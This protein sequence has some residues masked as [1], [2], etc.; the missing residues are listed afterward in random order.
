MFFAL[1]FDGFGSSLLTEGASKCFRLRSELLFESQ[2][3]PH[4]V[5]A[6]KQQGVREQ[7]EVEEVQEV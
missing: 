7:E 4:V 3:Q 6:N 1:G 2:Q 5:Y